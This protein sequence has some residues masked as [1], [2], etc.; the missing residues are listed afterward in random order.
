M[1]LGF[2]AAVANAILNYQFGGTAYTP[3]GT[4]YLKLHT[5]D[6][7]AAGT[8]APATNAVRKAVTLGSAASGGV[9]V[10]TAIITW[11][12]GEVT[13][14]ETYTHWSLWSAVTAGVFQIDGILNAPRPVVSGIAVDVPIGSLAISLNVAT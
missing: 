12:A 7:G 11:S 1:A 2:S 8:N 9:K 4:Y 14:T 10:T 13:A 3:P 6:P 5:G